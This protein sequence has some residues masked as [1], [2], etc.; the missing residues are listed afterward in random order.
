MGMI[1]GSGGAEL[2]SLRL[3]NEA[4]RDT[5]RDVEVSVS[6]YAQQPDVLHVFAEDN[7]LNFDN[8]WAGGQGRTTS[9][10]PAGH[11]RLVSF[12]VIEDVLPD[13]GVAADTCGYLA[14]VPTRFMRAQPLL[15]DAIHTVFITVAGANFDAVTYRGT[16]ALEDDVE[17]VD[18]VDRP[19]RTLLWAARPAPWGKPVPTSA[20]YHDIDGR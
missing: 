11:A 8:P 4:G 3:H 1:L 17:P 14:T 12:A 15:R 6:V 16:I 19:M 5:A 18:G 10:V 13:E 7:N 20:E 9:T 2:L